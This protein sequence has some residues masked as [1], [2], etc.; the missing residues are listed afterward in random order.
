M[1]GSTWE[2]K[3]ENRQK[4][5]GIPQPHLPLRSTVIIGHASPAI[6][7]PGTFTATGNMIPRRFL[8]TARRKV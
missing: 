5:L 1:G 4:T 8:H 3:Y 7:T 2:V 6:T